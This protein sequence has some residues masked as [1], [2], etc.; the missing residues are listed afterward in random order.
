MSGT[1]LP[2]IASFPSRSLKPSTL[3]LATALQ[4]L[5][6]A[7][8]DTKPRITELDI[9]KLSCSGDHPTITS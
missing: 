7:A 1:D 3:I 4:I 2:Q 8:R 5:G 6:G 9:V